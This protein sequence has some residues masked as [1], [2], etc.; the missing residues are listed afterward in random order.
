MK[1]DSRS[2][3]KTADGIPVALHTLDVPGGLRARVMDYGATLVELQVP[4]HAGR[5]AGVVLGFETLAEYERA[6]DAYFGATVGRCANRIAGASFELDGETFRLEANESPNHLHGG[7]RGFD[8]RVW[9][10]IPRGDAVTFA[11]TSRDGDQGYPGT[12]EVEVRYTASADELCIEYVATTDRPTLVNLTHH[13]YFDLGGAGRVEDHALELAAAR[14]TPTDA[15]LLPTGAV[16]PVSGT[17]LDFT[18]PTRIAHPLDH[19]FVLDAPW[20]TG[21]REPTRAAV[22]RHAASGRTLEL[23]TTEPGLQ[24]YTGRGAVCLEPQRFPDAVHQP[25]FPSVVLRPGERY[26]QTSIYRFRCSVP[27]GAS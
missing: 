27:E 7:R 10:A 13:S 14:F 17:P 15:A 25:A 5:R 12:L 22:L 20:G 23:F 2:F 8:K 24:V 18:T 21:R 19:N 3:G 9:R 4:D 16:E 6:A 26:E 1:Q 11:L